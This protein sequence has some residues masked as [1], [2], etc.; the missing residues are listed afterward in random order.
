MDGQNQCLNNKK[1]SQKIPHSV[2]WWILVLPNGT[3]TNHWNLMAWIFLA[4][5]II[6]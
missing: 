1:S 5:K 2:T 6:F 3:I 4:F